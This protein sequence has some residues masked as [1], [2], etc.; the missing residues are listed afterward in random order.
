MQV[1]VSP[2]E[3]QPTGRPVV[4]PV[5]RPVCSVGFASGSAGL[6]GLV[7]FDGWPGD[8]DLAPEA[9]DGTGD[10]EGVVLG[11]VATIASTA[12]AIH[13]KAVALMEKP[14]A[15]RARSALRRFGVRPS[16]VS[17]T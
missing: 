7:S 6:R 10:A 14:L 17:D 5:R 11:R 16:R 8:V 4:A 2:S 13:I 12:N 15:S 9:T 1:T 3:V